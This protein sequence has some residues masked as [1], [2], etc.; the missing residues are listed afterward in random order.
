MI[1]QPAEDSYLLAKEVKKYS[2]GRKVLDVGAGSGILS[3]T[4]LESGAKSTIALDISPEAVSFL[5]SQ[6]LSAVQSDLFSNIKEKFDLIVFNPPYLPKDKRE[7]KAS[8][9]AT[10]GGKK[11]DEIILKFLKNVKSHLNKDGVTLIL[12]SSLTPKKRI[13]SILKKQELSYSIVSSSKLF[14][15]KL[16]VWK[17][18]SNI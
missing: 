3:K 15:E 10:T 11:G 18:S 17:I 6:G 12:V 7:D 5:K 4:A 8:Q 14:M 9:L 16:E 13:C 1:Y 2:K